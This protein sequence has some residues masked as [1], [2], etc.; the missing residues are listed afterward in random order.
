[1]NTMLAMVL[2]G[3]KWYRQLRGGIWWQSRVRITGFD[4]ITFWYHNDLPPGV[5]PIRLG[6]APE[7]LVD[8]EVY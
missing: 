6:S 1:M 3:W 7:Y 8:M 5:S 2:S 4:H